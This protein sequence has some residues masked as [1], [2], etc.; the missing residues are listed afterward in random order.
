MKHVVHIVLFDQVQ[1][2]REEVLC[3]CH[4]LFGVENI[5]LQDKSQYFNDLDSS[6]PYFRSFPLISLQFFTT[7][8]NKHLSQLY[9]FTNHVLIFRKHERN[10]GQIGQKDRWIVDS[11]ILF[12]THHILDD[13]SNNIKGEE[14]GVE[15]VYFAVSFQICSYFFNDFTYVWGYVADNLHRE[16]ITSISDETE[17][18]FSNSLKNYLLC[19]SIKVLSWVRIFTISSPIERDSAWLIILCIICS[20]KRYFI[21]SAGFLVKNTARILAI[22]PAKV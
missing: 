20:S 9:K 22:Y 4:Y 21:N 3:L 1:E 14:G 6:E 17:L 5:F 13:F 8:F 15:L 12:I 19:S 18:L 2:D 10:I 16:Q 7:L 11:N